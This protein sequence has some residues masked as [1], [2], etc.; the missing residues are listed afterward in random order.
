MDRQIQ[1]YRQAVKR[2]S[3]DRQTERERR[4]DR[5]PEETKRIDRN[6]Q[7]G[8]FTCRGIS[9]HTDRKTYIQTH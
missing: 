1:T 9:R 8:R 2:E 6:N 3:E 7:T 5:Q 4:A